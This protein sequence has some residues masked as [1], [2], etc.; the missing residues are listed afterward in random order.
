[1]DKRY[2]KNPNIRVGH[3]VEYY[4]FLRMQKVDRGYYVEVWEN[5]RWRICGVHYDTEEEAYEAGQKYL[6]EKEG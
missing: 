1:M 3:D 6:D 4:G 5:S 2:E